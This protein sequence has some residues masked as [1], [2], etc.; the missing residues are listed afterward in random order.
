MPNIVAPHE[1]HYV[2]AGYVLPDGSAHVVYTVPANFWAELVLLRIA[3]ATGNAGTALV[4]WTDSSLST[5]YTLNEAG[6]I[7]AGI[8]YE[9]EGPLH[10]EAGDTLTVTAATN[11]HVTLTVS[12]GSRQPA[13]A[14]RGTLAS[15]FSNFAPGWGQ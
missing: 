14:Q 4:T 6:A 12:Q 8:P 15:G 11:N 9:E 3:K 2:S 1:A 10:M 7:A 5:T 13:G